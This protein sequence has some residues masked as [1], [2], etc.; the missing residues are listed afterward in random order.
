MYSSRQA[1]LTSS[2]SWTD[3]L[4]EIRKMCIWLAENGFSDTPLHFSRFHPD[5]KLTNLPSTPVETLLRAHETARA[6]GLNYVYIGNVPGSEGQHTFCP[7]CNNKVIERNGFS[8]VGR[9]MDGN[10]C[11]KCG[12]PIAGVWN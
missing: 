1:I 4:G 10:N 7:S 5:Y 12:K 2:R 3:D 8:I 9:H 6:E 11:G